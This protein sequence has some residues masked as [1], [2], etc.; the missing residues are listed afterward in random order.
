M[1]APGTLSLKEAAA[2][3]GVTSQTLRRW[4]EDGVVPRAREDG[5]TDAAV[6]HARV[7]ARLRERGHP[8]KEIRE[9]TRA[10]KLAF[11]YVEDLIPPPRPAYTLE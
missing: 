10:G 2:R 6:A 5:W 4:A 1:S 11:S 7:V 9:A 3:A 8:L